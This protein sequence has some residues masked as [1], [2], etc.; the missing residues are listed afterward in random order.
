[1]S[2]RDGRG[3]VDDEQHPLYHQV[4]CKCG[5]VGEV[6]LCVG[7]TREHGAPLLKPINTVPSEKRE[8][9]RQQGAYRRRVL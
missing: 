9:H 7:G 8:A 5:N 1:M 6:S 3:T 2:D 4:M